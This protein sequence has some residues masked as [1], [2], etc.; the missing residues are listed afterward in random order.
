MLSRQRNDTRHP[1]FY[2]LFNGEL[3]SI[4]VIQQSNG[5]NSIRRSVVRLRVLSDI[6]RTASLELVTVH[7]GDKPPTVEYDGLGQRRAHEVP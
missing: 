2:C 6:S 1:K 5:K 3:K 4:A 7:S